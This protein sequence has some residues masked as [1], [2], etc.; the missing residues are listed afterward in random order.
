MTYAVRIVPSAAKEL[1]RL[2]FENQRRIDSR[3][4][5]LASNPRSP[6]STPLKGGMRGLWRTRV[7]DYRIIYEIRDSELVVVVAKIGHRREI[8]RD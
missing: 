6:G 7:G 1:E 2:S 3:I 8:Y 5:D 4:S